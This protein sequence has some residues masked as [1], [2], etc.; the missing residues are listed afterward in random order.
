MA[1]RSAH[2]GGS[3]SGLLAD[4]LRKFLYTLKLISLTFKVGRIV[5]KMCLHVHGF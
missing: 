4:G 2:A 1:Q 3:R 5:I